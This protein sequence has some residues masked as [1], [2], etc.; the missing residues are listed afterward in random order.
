MIDIAMTNDSTFLF[1]PLL[2]TPKFHIKAMS[3]IYAQEFKMICRVLATS[4]K[5]K[6]CNLEHTLGLWVYTETDMW[7]M[8]CTV[9]RPYSTCQFH[10][11]KKPHVQCTK[12]G[13]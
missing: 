5:G 12:D 4:E 6:V 7:S 10:K 1:Q 11:V 3:W 2:F 8:V 13:R 9:H